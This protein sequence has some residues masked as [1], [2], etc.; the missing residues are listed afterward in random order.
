MTLDKI[1]ESIRYSSAKTKTTLSSIHLVQKYVT[2]SA[3]DILD[4]GN[5]PGQF[6]KDKIRRQAELIDAQYREV[7]V[8][9]STL[10]ESG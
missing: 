8:M 2:A 1:K 9:L 10:V 6:T 5:I 7:K 3:I 4:Q